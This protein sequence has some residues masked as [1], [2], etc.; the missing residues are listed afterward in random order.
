MHRISKFHCIIFY[1]IF[2]IHYLL[3]FT[4]SSE[5]VYE[6]SDYKTAG[7]NSC[8]FNKNDT[9]L[10]VN[11]NI[12]VV[13]TNALGKNISEP[14]EVDVAF[15]GK[16]SSYCTRFSDC[17]LYVSINLL[18]NFYCRSLFLFVWPVSF[19]YLMF[20][21]VW[22]IVCLYLVN[23]YILNGTRGCWFHGLSVTSE[24]EHYCSTSGLTVAKD[25]SILWAVK[26]YVS[27][28]FCQKAFSTFQIISYHKTHNNFLPI[29]DWKSNCQ[30]YF[31]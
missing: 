14:V 24:G 19:S 31:Y 8:F 25:C 7:E 20:F 6:C 9:S 27:P 3:S 18:H 10:W 4:Y 13:A 11:Y 17:S 30:I 5:T 22:F 16:T 21:P 26:Y 15:I 12:T 2:I 29:K 23:W 1:L 28:A